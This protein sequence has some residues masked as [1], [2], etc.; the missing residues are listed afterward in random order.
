MATA[1]HPQPLPTPPPYPPHS[2]PNPHSPSS[3]TS[4]PTQIWINDK[5]L[6]QYR[7]PYVRFF[8]WAYMNADAESD[9]YNINDLQYQK[10]MWTFLGMLAAHIKSV[11]DQVRPRVALA[12]ALLRLLITR[13][14]VPGPT[15]HRT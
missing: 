9:Q 7:Q 12:E 10:E 1:S 13:G 5:I 4:T 3:P 6:I 15:A 2:H 11:S 14:N 8:L